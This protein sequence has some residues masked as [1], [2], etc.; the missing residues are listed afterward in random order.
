MAIRAVRELSDRGVNNFK[1]LLAGGD[2]TGYSQ[3]LLDLI[4]NFK[5][6]E[7]VEYIGFVSDMKKL[8]KRVDVELMCAPSEA[9]GLVTVE[10]MLAGNLVIGSDSGATSELIKDGVNGYLY[11]LNDE[12]DLADKME[13]IIKNSN[14]LKSMG[15]K[16][17]EYA[18]NNFTSKRH[19]DEIIKLYDELLREK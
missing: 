5:I 1:L 15:N 7:R 9:F 10:A 19:S 6:S 8:R 11:Q 4:K 17:K 18:L 13:K 14:L 16:A 2:P 12:V 3:Y